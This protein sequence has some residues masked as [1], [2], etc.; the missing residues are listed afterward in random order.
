MACRGRYIAAGSP[1]GISPFS[2]ADPGDLGAYLLAALWPPWFIA[3]F[4]GVRWVILIERKGNEV[5][6]E[7]VRDWRK[8]Q[9]RIREIAAAAAA[10]ILQKELAARKYE[11]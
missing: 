1:T 7:R 3:K 2:A 9:R 6:D 8:S 4:L 11:R 10:G 5:G